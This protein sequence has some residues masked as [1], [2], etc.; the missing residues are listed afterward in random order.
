MMTKCARCDEKRT[1]SLWATIWVCHPCVELIIR[2]W[3][4][5]R[6]EYAELVKS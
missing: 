1:C 6:Q 4:L 5:K 3:N 2:E